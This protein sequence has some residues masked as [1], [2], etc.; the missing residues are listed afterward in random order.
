MGNP[1]SNTFFSQ[2]SNRVILTCVDIVDVTHHK[3]R[4][5]QTAWH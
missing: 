4:V 1:M 3:M 2:N 5:Y